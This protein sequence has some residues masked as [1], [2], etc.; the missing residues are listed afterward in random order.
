MCAAVSP[1]VSPSICP[2]IGSEIQLSTCLEQVVKEANEADMTIYSY[3][4]DEKHSPIYYE[5]TVLF[6]KMMAKANLRWR[7]VEV[8]DAMF[9]PLGWDP[10]KSILHIPGAVS[11]EL[12]THLKDKVAEIREF[13]NRGGK[14]LGW[15]GGSYWAC[16]EV[17]YRIDD[18]AT[19]HKMRE[20]ALWNGI[21]KGPLLPFLG[22]PEG[23]VGFFHGAV[24]VKWTGSATL[25]KYFPEG[26]DVN[27]LLSGGGSFI[28]AVDE[29]PHKILAA[30]ADSDI[31]ADKILAGVKTYVGEGVAILINPYFTHGADYFKPGLEGYMKYFP[32]HDWKKIIR[33]LEGADLKST[34][35]FADMLL[36]MI[37]K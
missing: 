18:H 8:S 9:A 5:E 28:P 10:R 6:I 13:V 32:K 36:E 34:L 37:S 2:T 26:L 17:Q 15:C 12:D 23:T 30:Y 29:H 1:A 25:K 16:R 21:Q 31:E 4:G 35:C 11:S 7:V 3:T 24:K 27:V 14:F 22:N 20:L 19:L 33:D